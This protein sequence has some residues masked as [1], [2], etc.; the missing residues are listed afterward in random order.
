[1]SKFNNGSLPLRGNPAGKYAW[2]LVVIVKRD[3]SFFVAAAN[4]ILKH[5][6]VLDIYYAPALEGISD[7][8]RLMFV[9]LSCTS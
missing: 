1:M 3:F 7:D 9:C 2:M 4:T 6:M 8:P 5:C